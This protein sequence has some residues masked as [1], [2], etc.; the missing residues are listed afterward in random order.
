MKKQI[1]NQKRKWIYLLLFLFLLLMFIM[2]IVSR[3]IN[4]NYIPV[5]LTKRVNSGRI[6]INTFGKGT[7]QYGIPQ[8]LQQYSKIV[9]E[10]DFYVKGYFFDKVQA[11]TISEGNKIKINIHGMKDDIYGNIIKKIYNYQTDKTEVILSLSENEYILGSEVDFVY[12]DNKVYYECIISKD[13]LYQDEDGEYLYILKERDSILGNVTIA[14]KMYV[15]V[16]VENEYFAAIEE[17]ININTKLIVKDDILR[18]GIRVRERE[19]KY[20]LF[21]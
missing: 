21:C 13:T 14:Y 5:V 4:K 17:I 19:W 10:P 7:I 16:L 1:I 8:E 3:A 15:H 2:T 11:E 12:E 9:I 20:L 18:D 6:E